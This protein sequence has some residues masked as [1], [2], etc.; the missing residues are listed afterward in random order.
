MLTNIKK[1]IKRHK[2]V[3]GYITFW[4]ITQTK[5]HIYVFICWQKRVEMVQCSLKALSTAVF[6]TCN[7][8]EKTAFLTSNQQEAPDKHLQPVPQV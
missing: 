6:V 8:Q 4:I 5:S 1:K 7:H 3:L 2:T